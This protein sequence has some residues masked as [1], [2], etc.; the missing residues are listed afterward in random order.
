MLFLIIFYNKID[1]F[2]K[3][4]NEIKLEILLKSIKIEHND[5]KQLC[6]TA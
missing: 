6:M 4:N 2:K 5:I 3:K 1:P